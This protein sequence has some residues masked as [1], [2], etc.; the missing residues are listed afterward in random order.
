[1]L[2]YDINVT[3]MTEPSE[4]EQINWFK[5]MMKHTEF[6]QYIRS[7]EHFYSSIALQA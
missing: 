1:M 6:I 2:I 7:I 4:G 3:N 5:V